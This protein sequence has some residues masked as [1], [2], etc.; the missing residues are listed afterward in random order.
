[1]LT[2]GASHVA[3]GLALLCFGSN[4]G[5]G[6]LDLCYTFVPYAFTNTFF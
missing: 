5:F 4:L 6:R 3:V 1:M 2:T